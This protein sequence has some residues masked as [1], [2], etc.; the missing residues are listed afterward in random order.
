MSLLFSFLRKRLRNI[1]FFSLEE[2]KVAVTLQLVNKK[3]PLENI[4]DKFEYKYV[5]SEGF[6]FHKFI[7]FQ[8]RKFSEKIL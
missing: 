4:T 2:L 8:V 7:N 1:E 5:D 3:D 6:G